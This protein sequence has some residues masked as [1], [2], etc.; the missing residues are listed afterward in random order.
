MS[1]IFET[2]PAAT[3]W[4]AYQ[5]VIFDCDSTLSTIEGVDELCQH[6]GTRE[7]VVE[8]TNAAM[9]GKLPLDQVYGER[10]ALIEPTREAVRSLSEQYRNSLVPDADVVIQ[11]LLAHGISVYIVSGGL[12]E[13][14][15]EFGVSLG[16]PAAHIRA[17]DLQYDQLCDGWWRSAQ[18]DDQEQARYL[19]Y[20]QSALALSSGKS[21]IIKEL[22]REKSG[23][24]VLF[25]DGASDL[26]ARNAVDLFVGF[27]GVVRRPEVRQRA[28]VFIDCPTL[29]PVLPI[30][31]GDPGFFKLETGL[32]S[33]TIS[34]I[35]TTPLH[36]NRE[37][38]ASHFSRSFFQ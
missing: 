34:C 37:V 2:A 24:S 12:L 1:S 19:T 35:K 14:V 27:G 23:G 7:K 21:E 30:A 29:L 31:L 10:L 5:H 22:L 17:V 6:L 25:G 36:F 15:L 18:G 11:A 16:I 4:P 38:L 8:L 20:R 3:R 28:P 9:D 26:M 33:S 13:P 32:R